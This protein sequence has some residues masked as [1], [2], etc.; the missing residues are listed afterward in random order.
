MTATTSPQAD[1]QHAIDIGETTG[2]LDGEDLERASR[3]VES[4]GEILCEALNSLT[5]LWNVRIT[6]DDDDDVLLVAQVLA[7]A[8]MRLR[9]A[10]L[11]SG[12]V[13]EERSFYVVP[14]PTLSAAASAACVCMKLRKTRTTRGS[15]NGAGA[16]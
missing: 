1:L 9:Q 12:L 4:G 2:H 13:R 15:D 7:D 14:G 8:G 16:P 5:A 3:L 10:A 6:C 11:D